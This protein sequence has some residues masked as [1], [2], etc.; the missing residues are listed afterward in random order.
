MDNAIDQAMASD[1]CATFI[2]SERLSHP[3]LVL[4]VTDRVTGQDTLKNTSL[5]A[6]EVTSIEEA[7]LR[8]L[9]DWELLT[10]LNALSPIRA[11]RQLPTTSP[12]TEPNFTRL[13]EVGHRLVLAELEKAGILFRVPE[14]ELFA[15]IWPGTD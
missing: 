11:P 9:T 4:R 2:R 10:R 5:F 13:I 1:A 15:T 8:L 14:I 7:E 3:L 12:I 6:I